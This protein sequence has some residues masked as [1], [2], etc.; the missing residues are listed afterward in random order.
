MLGKVEG[1]RRRRQ[2]WMRWLDGIT[3]SMDVSLGKLWELVMDREAWCAAVP[4]VTNSRTQL[5]NR[6][7]L[8]E[9]LSVRIP[10]RLSWLLCLQ[11]QNTKIK[12]YGSF[13]DNLLQNSFMLF[14]I[15][16]LCSFNSEVS[17]SF[18]FSVGA[19]FQ[20]LEMIYIPWHRNPSISKQ[21]WC[22]KSIISHLYLLWLLPLVR[23]NCPCGILFLPHFAF[24][25]CF[26]LELKC[27]SCR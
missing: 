13:E 8:T 3:D 21:Q 2:Q 1:S 16:C 7:E 15:S 24:S 22:I 25:L 20:L 14:K 19:H 11:C 27:L 9:F 5:S 10:G 23:A 4:E 12:V 17:T 26:A 6:T 18:L